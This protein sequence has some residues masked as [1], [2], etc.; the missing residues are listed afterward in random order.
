MTGIAVFIGLGMTHIAT[1]LILMNPMIF[2]IFRLWLINFFVA[3]H[4]FR[5]VFHLIAIRIILAVPM[6]LIRLMTLV[7]FKIF[8]SVDIRG[9]PFILAKI[10]FLN[11]APMACS[12]DQMHGRPFLEEVS[13]Q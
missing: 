2:G 3:V 10:L 6:H 4:A 1:H 11:T 9:H 13:I 12:A 8:L 5:A 7:T